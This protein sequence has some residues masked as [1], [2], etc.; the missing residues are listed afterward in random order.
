MF[1]LGSMFASQ[2]VTVADGP[3]KPGT[4]LACPLADPVSNARNKHPTCCT[5]MTH[6]SGDRLCHRPK[7]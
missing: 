4:K 7:P 6:I 2:L 3:P 5:H 1:G